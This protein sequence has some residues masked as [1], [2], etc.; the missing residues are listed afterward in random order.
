MSNLRSSQLRAKLIELN[1]PISFEES[2]NK[3]IIPIVSALSQRA[4]ERKDKPYFIGLQ[5]LQ[6][7]GK[8]S[9]SQL[10][11]WILLELYELETVVMSID[12]FY[13]TRKEREQLAIDIHPLLRTRGVPG[14]HDIDLCTSI[15]ERLSNIDSLELS[16]KIPRFDKH[17]DDRYPLSK[18]T[19]IETTPDIIL[20][21]GWCVGVTAQ[22]NKQLET[23]INSLEC[24]ND[25]GGEWR[26]FVNHA[27]AST[28]AN[29]FNSLDDLIVIK[30]PSFECVA[31]WR[32]E[33][34]QT[35]I[36]HRGHSAFVLDEANVLRFIQYFERLSRHALSTVDQ[37]AYCI[38]EVDEF[39]RIYRTQ[40]NDR[41]R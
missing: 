39:R 32:Y 34:E 10:M 1:I 15:I 28:Y 35:L 11:A 4:R 37:H 14:T 16:L 29:L 40:L 18:W 24:S 33:Q 7:S 3:W 22:S 25:V 5:G 38:I 31:S 9:L 41:V 23:P 2:V 30:A 20:L 13:L 12:D 8:S 17:I 6:G 36:H 26:Q 27:L 19:V 21:E